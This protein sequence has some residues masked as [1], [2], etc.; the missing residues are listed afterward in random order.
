MAATVHPNRHPNTVHRARVHRRGSGRT[1]YFRIY[2]NNLYRPLPHVP[3]R[4]CELLTFGGRSVNGRYLAQP[5][6]SARRNGEEIPNTF[7]L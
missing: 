4:S 5:G 3:T 7:L 6:A 2:A 1:D